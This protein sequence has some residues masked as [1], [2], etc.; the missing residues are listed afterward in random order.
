MRTTVRLDDELLAK[1]KL[2]AAEH[3]RT[4]TSVLE[5]ALREKLLPLALEPKER[6]W[7]GLPTSGRKGLLPG[8]DLDNSAGLLD[9]M[10]DL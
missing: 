4:L 7:V 5:E 9:V 8:I 10:E 3:N 6:P 1:A 2:Y